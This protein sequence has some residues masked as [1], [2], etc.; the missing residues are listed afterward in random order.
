VYVVDQ[1]GLEATGAWQG[2][3]TELIVQNAAPVVASSSIRLYDAASDQNL[4]LTVEEDQ[5]P[6]FRLEFTVND[7]NSC[8]A[9]GGGDEITDVDINVFRYDGGGAYAA[10]LGCDASGEYNANYCYTDTNSFFVPSCTQRGG[11]CTGD[12]DV[13]A[14][15]DCTFPMWYIADPTDVGSPHVGSDW[16]GS[17]RATDEA[18]TSPFSTLD[19]PVND[20][21]AS[22]M[23]QFL[24]FRATG[25]PIAYGA[26]EP[27]QNNPTHV[28]STTVYGTG[29]TGIDH[30]LSGDAMCVTY[31]ACSNNPT[32]TIYVPNQRYSLVL[33]DAWANGT[34]LTTST[35][36]VLVD[37]A[38]ASTTATSAPKND[39]TYWAI[40]VPGTITFAGDYVGEN[41]IDAAVAPSGDW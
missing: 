18:L 14:I 4:T 6:N 1:F 15:W 33:N 38:I 34:Q 8:E 36:P 5:T 10:A 26:L 27:G 41:F 12:T 30:Y 9:F 3:S 29:N 35:A 31:P 19:E 32:D 39:S 2:S 13:N 37:V 40:A 22:Q 25:S 7:D 28:A 11:S 17:A 16:R 21:F 24:S 20:A 23:E